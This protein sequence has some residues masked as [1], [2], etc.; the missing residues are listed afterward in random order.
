MWRRKKK[1][2][3]KTEEKRTEF[4]V[5]TRSEGKEKKE[6]SR[7]TS[8]PIIAKDDVFEQQKADWC[9]KCGLKKDSGFHIYES[10]LVDFMNYRNDWELIARDGDSKKGISAIAAPKNLPTLRI[11][12]GNVHRKTKLWWF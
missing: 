4:T 12:N 1:N 5:C 6:D 3:K 2:R 11:G 7:Q 9:Q 8:L 10:L